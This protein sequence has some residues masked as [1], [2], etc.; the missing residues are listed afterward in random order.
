MRALGLLLAVNTGVPLVMAPVAA[1]A[2]PPATT[3]SYTGTVAQY[4]VP[5]GVH[6]VVVDTWG[7]QGGGLGGHAGGTIA[8]TPGEVLP[9]RV[10]GSNGFNGGGAGGTF[11]G[12]GGGASDVRQG[13]GSLA[14]RVV[15]GG[16][17][18]GG[19][20]NSC[21]TNIFSEPFGGD[22]SFFGY[23]NIGCAR[24]DH[25]HKVLPG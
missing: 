24:A 20:V 17:G 4:T 10:G 8:V 11:G 12:N 14:D 21:C 22:G 25:H 9:V 15:I 6:Y 18:G 3:F 19:G 13:G 23:R 1:A 5:A 16:G 7:A 2:T